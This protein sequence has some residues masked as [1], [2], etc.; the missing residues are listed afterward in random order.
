MLLVRSESG[1]KL[2]GTAASADE[3]VL[4]AKGGDHDLALA[5]RR[6]PSRRPVMR[7]MGC[8]RRKWRRPEDRLAA[9][10]SRRRAALDDQSAFFTGL[11][12]NRSAP[13]SGL[14]RS[15]VV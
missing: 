15:V 13:Q 7:R 2:R 1:A 11:G 10:G 9:N 12:A 14:G 8:R 6:S 5:A 3:H 4:I